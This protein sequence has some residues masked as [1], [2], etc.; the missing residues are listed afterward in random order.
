MSGADPAIWVKSFPP[1][2]LACFL[3]VTEQE[4]HIHS[5]LFPADPLL[6]QAGPAGVI[7]CW[8]GTAAAAGMLS[9]EGM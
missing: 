1:G 5:G 6:S 4:F 9:W 2:L 3:G 7:P 8:Q